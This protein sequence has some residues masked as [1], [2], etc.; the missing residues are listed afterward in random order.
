MKQY[1]LDTNI[2]IE[3]KNRYYRFS[4]CQGFWDFLKYPCK[5]IFS[6]KE[7]YEELTSKEDELTTFSKEL[8]HNDFFKDNDAYDCYDKIHNVLREMEYEQEAIIDFMSKADF[9]LVAY[10]YKHHCMIVTHESAS[11]GI[12]YSKKRVKIPDICKKLNISCINT[13]DFLQEEKVCFILQN[14]PTP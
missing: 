1:I 2:F 8:K 11:Y 5:Q 6:L 12:N 3:A 14:P 9:A 13:F 10:A 7:V 4:V